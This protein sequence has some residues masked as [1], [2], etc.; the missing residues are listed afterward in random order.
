M[1]SDTPRSLTPKIRELVATDRLGRPP[2]GRL[3][4]RHVEALSAIARGRTGYDEDV[5]ARRAL[6]ALAEGARPEQA[7]PVLAEVLFDV[8]AATPDRVAAARGLARVATPEATEALAARSR[9]RDPR[10]QQAV[11]AGLGQVGGP[12]ELAQLAKLPVPGDAATRRQLTLTTALIA[13]RHGLDGPFLPE[14]PTPS[15]T[16]VPEEQRVNVALSLQSAKKTAVDRERLVGSTWGIRLADRSFA[17]G[18]GR[19]S[20]TLFVN[21]EVG[22]SVTSADRAFERPLIAGVLTRWYPHGVRARPQLLVLTR[23]QPEG[24]RLD[25]VRTDGRV[26][27]VGRLTPTGTGVAFRVT[28]AEH[29]AAAKTVVD[30]QV[31]G[32]GVRL[33]MAFSSPRRNTPETASALP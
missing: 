33:E 25:V 32:R 11:I 2:V 18:C 21:D 23:P 26:D 13:H 15:S 8:G 9:E 20:F 29:A 28:N 4:S 30:G 10:V 27:Y 17:V 31:T 5:S 6:T 1:P 12:G 16:D 24:A 19:S 7:V 22:E 3:T 14:V